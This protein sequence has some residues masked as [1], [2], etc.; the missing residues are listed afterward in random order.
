MLLYISDFSGLDLASTPQLFYT[1]FYNHAHRLC[2]EKLELYY[3]Q[4]FLEAPTGF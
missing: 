1:Y 2:L 3:I 4:N